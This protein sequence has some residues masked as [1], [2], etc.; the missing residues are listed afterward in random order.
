MRSLV[1]LSL[2]WFCLVAIAEPLRPSGLLYRVQP[3]DGAATSYLFGTIHSEDPRVLD[4]PDQVLRTFANSPRLAL[5]V[6]PDATAIIKAMVSMVYT[7]GRLLREVIPADLYRETAAALEALGMPE[8]AIKDLKPW[9][10]VLLLSVPPSETGEFLDHHL[11]TRADA[12]GKSVLGLETM[13][14]QLALFEDLS[15]SEQITLLRETLAARE[16]LADTVEELIRAYLDADLDRLQTLGD[17]TLSASDPA[18][19]ARFQERVIDSRNHRMVERMR[20]LL[21]EG[22]WFIAVGALHLPGDEGI[23]ALLRQQGYRVT[24]AD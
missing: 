12:E 18:L 20:P 8:E 2:A 22:G 1:C 4:L 15:E 7:D 11:Y 5:E 9:A 23:V 17:T 6:I 13:A 24:P 19:A 10:V 21:H 3:P 14:E 16:E